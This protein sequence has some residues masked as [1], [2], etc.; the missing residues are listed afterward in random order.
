M[1]KGGTKGKGKVPTTPPVPPGKAGH[2]TLPDTSLPTQPNAMN[3][4]AGQQPDQR[5]MMPMG[6]HMG[7]MHMGMGSMAMHPQMMNYMNMPT[8]MR[9]PMGMPMSMNMQQSQ[10]P[11][12]HNNMG[13]TAG[14]TQTM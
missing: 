1:E 13:S 5:M 11:M 10:P 6:M 8:P 12:Y 2:T 4:G 7:G 9:M 14:N 3:M